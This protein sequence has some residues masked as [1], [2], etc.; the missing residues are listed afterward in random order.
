MKTRGKGSGGSCVGEK[1][2]GCMAE[3]DRGLLPVTLVH[4]Y[5]RYSCFFSVP[6]GS[7]PPRPLAVCW[8]HIV[9]PKCGRLPRPLRRR[10]D[11]GVAPAAPYPRMA[12]SPRLRAHI[13][14]LVA[15][16]APLPRPLSSVRQQPSSPPSRL[17]LW[18]NTLPHPPPLPQDGR[19][20][21]LAVLNG[22]Q[23]MYGALPSH[24]P[25]RAQPTAAACPPP[26]ALPPSRGR[27]CRQ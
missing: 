3:N 20:S 21:D 24:P 8:S 15:P 18:R 17:R 19:A 10:R 16:A 26:I 13:G 27:A 6:R 5:S 12:H 25:R 7:P 4:M 22:E 14:G 1:R 9:M 2:V 11:P 23:R